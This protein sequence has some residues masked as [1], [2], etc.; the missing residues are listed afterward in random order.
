MSVTA[1]NSAGPTDSI[2]IPDFFDSARWK[3]RLAVVFTL[4]GA[5]A[6]LCCALLSDGVH[7]DDDL[8]HLQLA[9]WSAQRPEYLLDEWG[10]PGF[11]VLYALPAQLGWT[12]ARIFTIG[13][14]A[15]TAWLTYR[16]AAGC[17]LRFAEYTPALFWLQPAVFTASMTTL[18]EPVLA[19][20]WTAAAWFFM[21]R[22]FARSALLVSLCA[23]TRHEAI[24]LLPVWWIAMVLRGRSWRE[25]SWVFFVPALYNGLAWLFVAQTPAQL[26]SV[27]QPTQEYGSGGWLAMLAR[28]AMAAGPAQLALALSGVPWL[29]QRAAAR[30]WAAAGGLYFAAHTVFF[31]FGLFASGGYERFLMPLGPLVAVAAALMV[32]E[33]LWRFRR[34]RALALVMAIG[35]LWLGAELEIWAAFRDSLHVVRVA[36]GL[37]IA[38]VVGGWLAARGIGQAKQAGRLYSQRRA[39]YALPTIALVAGIAFQPFVSANLD[40][41]NRRFVPLRLNADQIAIRTAV[42]RMSEMGLGERPIVAANPWVYEFAGRMPAYRGR[43]SRQRL[44]ELAPGGLF[45]WESRYAPSP[46]FQLTLDVLARRGYLVEVWRSAAAESGLACIIFEKTAAARPTVVV[47]PEPTTAPDTP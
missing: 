22:A 24:L 36:A 16:I 9:R 32:E 41:A 46:S 8:Q 28:W 37:L 19:L 3:Y 14:S 7:H 1:P 11:T 12:F 4:A 29:W 31:R 20:Y 15:L 25:W 5:L 35:A 2:S 34:E 45:I 43:F 10:R 13:L 30:P 27:L 40:E 26:F 18:T 38:T 33:L 21:R 23:V 17:G 39:C 6:A 44:D 47:A 42:A